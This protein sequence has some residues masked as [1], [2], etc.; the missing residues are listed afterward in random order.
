MNIMQLVAVLRKFRKHVY[1][2]QQISKQIRAMYDNLNEMELMKKDIEEINGELDAF[3]VANS[4]IKDTLKTIKDILDRRKLVIPLKATRK[5]GTVNTDL[6]GDSRYQHE[7]QIFNAGE[8]LDDND[9]FEYR[10]E[11]YYE[12]Y[13]E[14]DTDDL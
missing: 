3:W 5:T 4:D 8:I 2:F 13:D 6:S 7:E 9:D 12:Y 11:E 10:Y 1:I 14:L